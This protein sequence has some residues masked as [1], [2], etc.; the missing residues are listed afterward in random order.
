M[1]IR[2]KTK[3]TCMDCFGSLGF[4]GWRVSLDESKNVWFNESWQ[5]DVPTCMHGRSLVSCKHDEFRLCT[6]EMDSHHDAVD[7]HLTCWWLPVSFFSFVHPVDPVKF[8]LLLE[9]TSSFVKVI[10]HS[11]ERE[12]DSW[13]NW[14]FCS[15]LNRL[16]CFEDQPVFF[17]AFS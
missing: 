15:K 1:Y 7:S 5:S 12:R 2:D 11:L 3:L 6:T 17:C 16:N 4:C 9:F 10:K 13:R 8:K 14:V